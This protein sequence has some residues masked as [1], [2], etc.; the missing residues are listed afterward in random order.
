MATKC[1]K[2]GAL[3][4]NIHRQPYVTDVMLLEPFGKC[5]TTADFQGSNNWIIED[6]ILNNE[7]LIKNQGNCPVV[8]FGCW[9]LVPGEVVGF[10]SKYDINL[11][12]IKKLR[13][14]WLVDD[15][16]L[17]VLDADGNPTDEKA[18]AICELAILQLEYCSDQMSEIKESIR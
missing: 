13:A 7:I 14:K 17:C 16:C 12:K 9:K 3:D 2:C 4:C 1:D 8:L 18:K 10:G 15:H 5:Y 6:T 11:I